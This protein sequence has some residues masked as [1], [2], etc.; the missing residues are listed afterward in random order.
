MMENQIELI[1]KF[2]AIW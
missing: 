1:L 2:A